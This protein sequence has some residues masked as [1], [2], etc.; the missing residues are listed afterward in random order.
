MYG[1]TLNVTGGF[2]NILVI[3]HEPDGGENQGPDIA[4]AT[5]FLKK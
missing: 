2:N 1:C 3:N 4:K 5:E